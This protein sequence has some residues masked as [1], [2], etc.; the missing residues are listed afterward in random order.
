MPRCLISLLSFYFLGNI[1]F[2]L[3]P[4]LLKWTRLWTWTFQPLGLRSLHR[5]LLYSRRLCPWPW[6]TCLLHNI[7]TPYGMHTHEVTVTNLKWDNLM[8]VILCISSN[9]LMI[10][11][12]LLPIALSWGLR[13]SCLHVATLLWPSVGV[14]PNTWKKW[15]FGVLRDSRMFRVRQ[16]GPKHL[17]LKCSWC[18]WKGLEP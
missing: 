14:K 5:R 2:H 6:K 15:G 4:L 17:A 7:E 8:L 10:L 12:T 11:W 3:L 18:H 16:Q 9:N 1:L 13:R